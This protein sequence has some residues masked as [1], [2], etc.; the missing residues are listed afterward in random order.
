VKKAEEGTAQV[1]W[2]IQPWALPRWWVAPLYLSGYVLLDHISFV[3][4]L[5][6]FGITPWNPPTGLSFVLILLA[7][8]GYLPLLFLAPFAAD[9]LLR[10]M[11]V[12]LWV[13][14]IDIFIVG[15]GYAA[16]TLVL[17]HPKVSFDPALSSRRDL[18]CLLL[19]A[20]VSSGL[21]ALAYAL[22]YALVGLLAWEQFQAATFH[23]WV[24]DAIGVFV[25][26]PFLLSLFT[27]PRLPRLKTEMAAQLAAIVLTLGVVFTHNEFF[28]LLFL[29]IIWIAVRYGLEGVSAGLFLMQAGLIMALEWTDQPVGDAAKF[30]FLMLVLA[31]TGLLLGIAISEQRRAENRLRL[32]EEA[33]ARA[34]RLSS[35]SIL[36]ATLA[37]EVNQPLTAIG[38][39]ARVVRDMIRGGEGEAAVALETSEK[40]IAQVDHAAKL[41]RRFR[42][43]VRTGRSEM[44]PTSLRLLIEETLK[45]ARPLLDR[46]NVEVSTRIAHGIGPVLM[47]RLQIEQVLLNLIRNSVEAIGLAGNASGGITIDIAPSDQTGFVDFKVSDDGPGFGRENRPDPASSFTTTKLEGLGLG[48]TLSRAIIER[49]AGRLTLNNSARGGVVMVSLPVA[50][51]KDHAT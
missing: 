50:G 8:R 51:E 14:L 45:V 3:F 28:Y 44:V 37:H 24:G 40:L 31:L 35:L 19:V 41:I 30:Q 16:A 15:A 20:G 32:H 33:L 10:G 47:D 22:L 1:E 29:P 26:T 36:A 5:V 6:P 9:L 34:S 39:Y 12:P 23:Y 42:E 17:S 25:I 38:N 46:A 48:L 7:G 2:M 18:L 11:P 21:V 43:F 13:E 27:N 4:P 49:H